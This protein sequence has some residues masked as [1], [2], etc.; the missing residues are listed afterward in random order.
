MCGVLERVN[1]CVR[2]ISRHRCHP[3]VRQREV[4]RPAPSLSPHRLPARLSAPHGHPGALPKPLSG[5]P[6]GGVS[7]E[8][9]F[10]GRPPRDLD[11]VL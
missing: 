6:V 7:S 3:P 1:L 8:G 5:S 9:A 4:Y 10:A 2:S 11:E